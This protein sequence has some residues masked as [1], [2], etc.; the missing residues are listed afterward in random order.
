MYLGARYHESRNNDLGKQRT[1]VAL[2][3]F[4]NL[5]NDDT[6]PDGSHE[7]AVSVRRVEGSQLQSLRSLHISLSIDKNLDY[8]AIVQQGRSLAL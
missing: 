1:L 5:S 6:F 2:E 8:S 3:K 7:P 4:P